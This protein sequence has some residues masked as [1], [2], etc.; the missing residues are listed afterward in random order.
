MVVSL[1][2]LLQAAGTVPAMTRRLF[3]IARILGST[4][5]TLWLLGLLAAAPA[6]GLIWEIEVADWIAV[7]A[8]G[9]TAN[10]LAA[11][12]TSSK[13]R[14]KPLLF[15]FHALLAALVALIALQNPA[16]P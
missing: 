14:T 7:P 12:W 13:L 15:A 16:S 9:L 5:A 4:G 11:L 2:P 6:A 3:R 1:L 8:A 10:L